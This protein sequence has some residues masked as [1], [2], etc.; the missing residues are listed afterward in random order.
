MCEFDF[1]QLCMTPD[2]VDLVIYHN[3]CSD[4]FGSA[5]CAYNYFKKTNG[6]NSN[7][8]LIEYFGAQFNQAPPNVLN[9]NVL[10]CDFSYKNDIMKSILL[11]ANKV[12]I[13]D[14]HKSAEADLKLV[15][16]KN[17]IFRMDHSGAYITWKYF[18]QSTSSPNDLNKV[19]IQSV[20][21]GILYIEDN[22]IW[23]KEMP[24]SREITAFI[25]SL[26]FEFEEYMK[27]LDDDYIKNVAMPAGVGMVKQNEVY[28][29]QAIEHCVP[30]FIQ[31]G[32][33]YY[34]VVHVNSTVL[35]SEIGNQCLSN[36]KNA[37]FSAVYSMG[38]NDFYFSLRSMDDRADVSIV[39]SKFGG[40]GHRNAAG[41][42]SK[43][44]IIPGKLLDECHL[45]NALE[46]IYFGAIKLSDGVEYNVVYLNYASN[47]K[48][49]AKYLLQTR[50]I[51]KEKKNI[52]ECIS[53]NRNRINT[54]TLDTC[55]LAVIWNY[56][57][58]NNKTWFTIA[59]NSNPNLEQTLKNTYEKFSDFELIDG[60]IVFTSLDIHYT[61]N[62]A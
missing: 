56:D 32:E 30:K 53:V 57:G 40:G 18:N 27:L 15:S 10:I 22:D 50:Y 11:Q 60:R 47:K 12:V 19:S 33:Q 48:H 14:H 58:N 31:I 54:K 23:K 24:S 59:Y 16:D 34:F 52:Q 42:T 8:R 41:L 46:N 4:G 36:F 55:D 38:E 29:K 35:K 62:S 13:L 45:Y 20:P 21:N 44:K 7:G 17:K 28:I 39:A 2:E 1:S 3:K 61:L 37:D 49:I 9:R 6:L 25:F 5:L 51:D 26:P 43:Q